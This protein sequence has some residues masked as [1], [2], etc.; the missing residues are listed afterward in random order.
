MRDLLDERYGETVANREVDD[1]IAEIL[2]E[3]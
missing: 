3:T 2:D 1:L